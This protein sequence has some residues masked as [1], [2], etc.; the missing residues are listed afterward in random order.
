VSTRR[1]GL[2]LGGGG[3]AGFAYH[4]GALTALEVDRGWDARTADVIVGTSAGALVG[5]L[6]RR[7]VPA[8]DL[9]AVTVGAGP[10]GSAPD[11]TIALSGAGRLRPRLREVAVHG[12]RAPESAEVAGW[13]RRPWLFDPLAAALDVLMPESADITARRAQLEVALGERWPA[14][15]LWICATRRIDLRRVVFGLD[16]RCPLRSAVSASCA[17][18]GLT[19][20]VLVHGDGYVD[21]GV[22]S[23]TNADVLRAADVDL[24][25]VI[26]PMSTAAPDCHSA[27]GWIRRFARRKL[28]AE[29]RQ[30]SAVMP[31]VVLQPGAELARFVGVNFM[32]NTRARELLTRS[33]LDAGQQLDDPVLRA[34]LVR[35]RAPE[36]ETRA[37]TAS[38]SRSLAGPAGAS[39]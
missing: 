37:L 5:G 26:S 20:P 25:V 14:R 7:G 31:V 15:A 24:A 30:L 39:G 11:L 9:A 34:S 13:L 4:A 23:P 38:S 6:L 28:V 21:G 17:V 12:M 36:S 35:P 19:Q 16:R 27:G 1:I 3:A 33:F 2:V 22:G 8:S 32:D 18:P 29:V 10:S